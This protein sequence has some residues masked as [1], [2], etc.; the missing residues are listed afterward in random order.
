MRIFVLLWWEK[1]SRK[2]RISLVVA[3][4]IGLKLSR[5]PDKKRV[6]AAY[7]DDTS[8]FYAGIRP[9]LWRELGELVSQFESLDNG[10]FRILERNVHRELPPFRSGFLIGGL[11]ALHFGDQ[12]FSDYPASSTCEKQEPCSGVARVIGVM[13][14][15]PSPYH[16]PLTPCSMSSWQ[17]KLR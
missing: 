9:P 11:H 1:N 7:G 3:F 14:H 17:L 8:I 16:K 4:G 2:R 13:S 12:R 6:D 5:E 15:E 10:V